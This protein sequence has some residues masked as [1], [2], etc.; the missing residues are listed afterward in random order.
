MAIMAETMAG[1]NANAAEKVIALKT[2]IYKPGQWNEGQPFGYD[3]DN[4]QG[5]FA[6]NKT[7]ETYIESRK[8]N[9]V[10]MPLLFLAVADE[11]G[12]KLN[13]TTAPQHMFI[14][15]ENPET[16]EVQHLETTSGA[17]PQRLIWQRKVLPMTDRAIESGM[18]MKRLSR[19]QMIAVMAETLLQALTEQDDQTERLEVAEIILQEFPQFDVGLLH[20]MISARLLIQRE[21][22]PN[23]LDPVSMP[24]EARAKFDRL[25]RADYE[26]S[27]SLVQ[28]GWRPKGQIDN[29]SFTLE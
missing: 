8:G 10:N 11:I 13:I 14:Q 28:L 19:N 24:E 2:L 25:A 27:Q 29:E 7:L 9:C 20:K 5:R 1:S 26:A 22:V 23:Y 21:I 4:P 15:F 16:G 17:D 3:F 6:K 12:V 18:Y